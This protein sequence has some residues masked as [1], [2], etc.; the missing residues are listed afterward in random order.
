VKVPAVLNVVVKWLPGAMLPEL[1][2]P[3]SA[4]D[5]CVVE[6][7]FT[8]E[9]VVPIETLSGLGL[10]AVLVS[11]DEPF[12]I[13]TGVPGAGPASVGAV[14][15]PPHPAA[16]ASM[17]A[18]AENRDVIKNLRIAD[19]KANALPSR[20]DANTKVFCDLTPGAALGW[21]SMRRDFPNA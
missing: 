4:T 5:V 17:R 21:Y 14:E 13:E 2:W 6:S 7:L 15:D 20:L 12:T 8:H 1:H 18:R 16:S 9:T 10:Y 19:S 3:P 11:V